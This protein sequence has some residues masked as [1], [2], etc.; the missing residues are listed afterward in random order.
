M[1]VV[2]H[3]ANVFTIRPPPQNFIGQTVVSQYSFLFAFSLSTLQYFNCKIM[4]NNM[5]HFVGVVLYDH[6]LML[7]HE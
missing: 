3:L 2:L 6:E 4:Y 5:V 7:G 1:K